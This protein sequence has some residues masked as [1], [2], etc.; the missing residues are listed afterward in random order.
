MSSGIQSGGSDLDNLLL[1]IGAFTPISN[2][3]IQVSGTDIANRYAGA[4]HG[5][6]YGTT[7]IQSGGVDIGTLFASKNTFSLSA[8]SGTY[9]LTGE[10]VAF[11]SPTIVTVNAAAFIPAPG[12]ADYGYASFGGSVS[13]T[14]YQGYTILQFYSGVDTVVSTY[15]DTFQISAAS[16]PGVGLITTLTV[17][18]KIRTGASAT[19]IYNSSH[20]T[21]LWFWSG[22]PYTNALFTSAGIYSA[23]IV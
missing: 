7:G 15:G 2:V 19:Y 22:S 17:G 14:T 13:P 9:V 4:S 10:S 8:G 21:A 5:V 18:S 23:S 6:A 11:A 20:G 1:P 16:D 3:G 12:D